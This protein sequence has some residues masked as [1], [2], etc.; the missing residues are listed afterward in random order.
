MDDFR[1]ELTTTNDDKL[2]PDELPEIHE[3]DSLIINCVK[4]NNLRFL[5][6]LLYEP[7][8]NLDCIY[9]GEN[10]LMLAIR[11][12][13]EEITKFLIENGIDYNFE[14]K[15]FYKTIIDDGEMIDYYYINC[16]EMAYRHGMFEVVEMIDFLNEEYFRFYPTPKFKL[17]DR[18][19]KPGMFH[20][21][22]SLHEEF[23][24]GDNYGGR[25]NPTKT[26][27]KLYI[28][29]TNILIPQTE[30]VA[31]TRSANIERSNQNNVTKE[32]KSSFLRKRTTS[33][34]SRTDRKRTDRNWRI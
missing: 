23:F 5:D 22:I 4:T 21:V 3:I 6:L 15:I 13:Y 20:D 18:S 17:R 30:L 27:E 16:R 2:E 33:A 34:K 31:R 12:G 25:N 8:S 1:Q 24:S 10:M 14:K 19:E 11:L 28:S 7:D 32:N 29:H 9:Y 26:P